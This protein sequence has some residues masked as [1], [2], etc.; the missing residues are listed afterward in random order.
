MFSERFFTDLI[1][2]LLTW[3][4]LGALGTLLFTIRLNVCPDAAVSAYH[5]V[6]VMAE[7]VLAGCVCCLAGMTIR[8]KIRQSLHDGTSN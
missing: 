1:Q 2:L 8:A 3:V 6:G 4:L 5:S 7:H